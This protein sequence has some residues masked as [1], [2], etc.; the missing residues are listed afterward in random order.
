MERTL[1]REQN[2]SMAAEAGGPQL[3]LALSKGEGEAVVERYYENY[4]D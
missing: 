1:N 3:R 4:K 2:R